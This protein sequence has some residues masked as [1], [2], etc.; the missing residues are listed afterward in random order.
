M[1]R[2]EENCITTDYNGRKKGMK[3]KIKIKINI[4]NLRRFI[5]VCMDK[6]VL[7]QLL[8]FAIRNK[9]REKAG[10][11]HK[12]YCVGKERMFPIIII[13]SFILYLT[14]I[15]VTATFNGKNFVI[16]SQK[17]QSSF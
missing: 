17:Q 2:G 5:H 7:S 12:N 14:Y 10:N 1:C 16:L 9:G 6:I 13:H 4:G 3:R 11:T 8:K 15:C